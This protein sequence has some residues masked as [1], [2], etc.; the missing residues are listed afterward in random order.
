MPKVHRGGQLRGKGSEAHK[1]AVTGDTVGAHL[2]IPQ[3]RL[4]ILIKLMSMVSIVMAGAT[5]A[6]SLF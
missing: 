3:A 6:I 5:V 1:A 2:K 4:N